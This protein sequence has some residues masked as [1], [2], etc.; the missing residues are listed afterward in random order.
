MS[1]KYNPWNAFLCCLLAMPTCAYMLEG[2]QAESLKEAVFAGT[3][4]GVA[5]LFLRP[6]LRIL[7]APIGCLTLGCSAW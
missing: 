1:R 3:L 5:H 7:S 4:L 2:I 6:A